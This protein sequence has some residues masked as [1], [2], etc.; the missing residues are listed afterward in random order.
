MQKK[1]RDTKGGSRPP[2]TPPLQNGDLF[3]GI[4]SAQEGAVSAALSDEINSHRARLAPFFN[5]H[6]KPK[7]TLK[8]TSR[9]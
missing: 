7:E 5:G 8:K 6:A 1:L 4:P 9:F 3:A 2:E